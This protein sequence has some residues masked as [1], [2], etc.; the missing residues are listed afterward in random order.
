[1]T[2][3][4]GS[5]RHAV[6]PGEGNALSHQD[7]RIRLLATGEDT[8]GSFALHEILE[9]KGTEVPCRVHTREDQAI[10]VLKGLVV[11]RTDGERLP[12]GQGGCVLLPRGCEYTYAVESERARLLVIAVPAGLEGYYR[13]LDDRGGGSEAAA[14]DFERLVTVAARYGVAIAVPASGTAGEGGRQMEQA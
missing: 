6:P 9:E 2:W 11:F 4:V 13:E 7:G 12:L 10:Y 1:M 3:A 5:G 8:G 14:P